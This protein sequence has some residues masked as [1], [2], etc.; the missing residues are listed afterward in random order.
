[1]K[2][3]YGFASICTML[4][5][6][7]AMIGGG[8]CG[9][10]SGSGA[11]PA[12][13]DDI[14][15]GAQYEGTLTLQED[16]EDTVLMRVAYEARNVET[17]SSLSPAVA[18][19]VTKEEY[20]DETSGTLKIMEDLSGPTP[21][22]VE[23]FLTNSWDASYEGTEDKGVNAKEFLD[24]LEEHNMP[25]DQF[26]RFLEA[27]N[28]SIVEFLEVIKV[29][30]TQLDSLDGEDVFNEIESFCD[31]A[32]IEL[33]SFFTDIKQVFGTHRA[34]C[35]K[36]VNLDTGM[37][38]LYNSYISWYMAQETE[39]EDSFAA[40]LEYL[41]NSSA[42]TASGDRSKINPVDLG[43]LGLDVLKF[44]WDVIKDGKPQVQTE[45]AFT[46]VL[47]KGTTAL[48]YGNAKRN[49]TSIL[50]FKVTDAWIKSWVLIE[51]KF[52]GS[53][54][55]AATSP[56]FGGRYLQNVQ[57]DVESA[58]A[59]WGM[60]LNVSAQVSN[61]TNPGTVE[62]PDP[63]IDVVA[64]INAGWLFQSFGRSAYFRAKGSRGIWFQRWGE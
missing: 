55:Y 58:Y 56:K 2:S 40:F 1:M 47:R 45:G 5:L 49:E 28:H 15:P 29:Y 22:E 18:L 32:G 62:N 8:G 3:K 34:F 10:G 26:F 54:S 11:L 42:L 50:H 57:F 17:E 6:M 31:L 61:V 33:G 59:L 52:R 46:S 36:L 23:A 7:A 63:E 35:T 53:S 24:F 64:R 43:K 41:K 13:P 48:D 16:G 19:F 39:L 4:L 60:Y 44:G 9:G 27:L 51:T 20:L 30:S 12:S 37:H 25:M 38:S 14:Q 21:E